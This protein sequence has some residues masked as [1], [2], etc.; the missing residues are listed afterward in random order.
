MLKMMELESVPH[1]GHLSTTLLV[2]NLLSSKM[3]LSPA[4]FN[5]FNVRGLLSLEYFER[6]GGVG[7]AKLWTLPPLTS[8]VARL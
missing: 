2:D 3:V 7:H 4:D 8:F 6:F 1:L 5:L